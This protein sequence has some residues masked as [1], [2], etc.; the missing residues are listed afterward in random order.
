MARIPRDYRLTPE[1]ITKGPEWLAELK[2]RMRIEAPEG[3]KPDDV[4][5]N[6]RDADDVWPGAAR[7]AK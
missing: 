5:D 4:Y 7:Q 2:R 3:E 6:E 1:D